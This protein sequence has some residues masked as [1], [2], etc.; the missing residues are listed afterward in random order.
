[1]ATPGDL[2]WILSEIAFVKALDKYIIILCQDKGNFN[3]VIIGTDH[4][5][6]PF[7]QGNVEKAYSDL[8]YVLQS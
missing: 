6:L 7:P 1:M 5:Y 3:Q 2:S 8:L 4:E